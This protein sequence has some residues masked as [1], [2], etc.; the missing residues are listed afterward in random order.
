MK[1]QVYKDGSFEWRWRLIHTNGNVLA[2]SGE[3]YNSK[4]NALRAARRVGVN[5]SKAKSDVVPTKRCAGKCA[6]KCAI[7]KQATKPARRRRKRRQK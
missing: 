2:D 1:L 6:N 7:S 5:I 4:A 3:G